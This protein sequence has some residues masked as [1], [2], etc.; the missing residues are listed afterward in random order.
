[1]FAI[2]AQAFAGSEPHTILRQTF[3]QFGCDN[4]SDR[5]AQISQNLRALV[6]AL[7][8]DPDCQGGVVGNLT[9]LEDQITYVSQYQDIQRQIAGLE[10][11]NTD[12]INQA[13]VEE[14]KG[15]LTSLKSTIAANQTELAVLRVQL[16]Q[17]QDL[18]TVPYQKAVLHLSDI[19]RNVINSSVNNKKCFMKRSGE[20]S[21]ILTI[22]GS[23]AATVTAVNPVLS[24]GIAAG[25]KLIDYASQK[26]RFRRFDKGYQTLMRDEFDRT[27]A[28][29]INA[30]S[31]DYCRASDQMRL[32]KRKISDPTLNPAKTTSSTVKSMG[33]L[34]E[35]SRTEI[36]RVRDWL[37][38]VAA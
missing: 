18:K 21:Q 10:A 37:T 12:L 5:P 7:S 9:L 1:M 35:F 31:E 36:P 15:I 23:V 25:T 26:L 11:R 38:Q 19:A 16:E 13:M 29:A 32:L 3:A 20:F 30:L 27:V 14:D 28:C 33:Q 6:Q 24:V 22:V 34:I 4:S 2:S 17:K 8:S